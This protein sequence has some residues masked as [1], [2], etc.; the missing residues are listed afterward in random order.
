MEGPSG[1]EI[2]SGEWRLR[3]A[4][5][6]TLTADNFVAEPVAVDGELGDTQVRIAVRAVGVN[7][8][9]VLVALGMYPD[10]DAIIGGEGAGVVVALGAGVTN[11]AVGD[12][13]MGVFEG[14]GSVAVADCRVV[15]PI[16]ADWS[17]AAAAGVPAV[18]LTAYYALRDLARVQRGQRVLIHAGTGGVGMAAIALAR[19][20]GLEV[21]ATASPAKWPVLR[22]MGVAADHIGSS[23]SAEFEER[24]SRL[25][26][27]L[28]VDVVVNSL[29]GELTDAS[30]RLMPGGGSFIELGRTDVRDPSE[31]ARAH[32]GVSYQPFV[33]FEVGPDRLGEMLRELMVMFAGGDIAPVQTSAWD[34]RR[35]PETYRYLSQARHVGKTVISVPRRLDPDGTVLITGGTGV[36]G[37]VFAR[38]LVQKYG[39]RRLLL[40]SRSGAA[41]PGAQDL[42]DELGALG[43]HADVVACDVSDRDALAEVLSQVPQQHPLTG[44]VHTAGVLRDG[45]FASLT[46]DKWEPVLAA[47]ADAAWHL[48]ELTAASDPALF[49]LFSSA[50]GILGSPGQANYAA[51]N[52]FLDALAHYRQR[53]G[54]AGTSL[55]WG[56]WEQKTGLTGHLGDQDSAR[57]ARSGFLPMTTE[58][59][60]AMFDAAI[61]SGQPLVVP[62]RID[63]AALSESGAV[64]AIAGLIARSRRRASNEDSTQQSTLSALLQGRSDTEQDR[65]TLEFVRDQAAVVLGHDTSHMIPPEEPFKSLGFDSL[66]A[67]EFRNRLQ[68]ATGLK[69]PATIVFDHPTPRSLATHLRTQITPPATDNQSTEL[70]ESDLRNLLNRLPID[71]IRASGIAE[72]ARGLAV[73]HPGSGAIASP[74]GESGRSIEELDANEL[75]DLAMGH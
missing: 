21:F 43:A 45:V 20:W 66:S 60:L 48:H 62:A 32:P 40:L 26:R 37:A 72:I 4:G 27:G 70:S 18:F 38:H 58:Q 68:T 73:G 56:F 64:P 10:P 63:T 65:I 36:L 49:V 2:G 69:I 24:F 12:R 52:T 33:L 3:T 29:A 23:R 28:G 14:V 39:V 41:A 59:G 13:V 57:M 16:P 42:V 55:A 9:D 5:A 6:G 61:E 71:I 31:V 15:A 35:L 67:V 74:G 47:K 53:S 34:V 1:I 51:A 75:I 19:L 50:A 25:T 44:V 46:A 22:S 7:F 17:F 30:L 11:V 8:R 54:S